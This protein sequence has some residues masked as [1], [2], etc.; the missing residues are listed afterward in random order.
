[1]SVRV[2]AF[3]FDGTLVASNEIKANAFFEVVRDRPGAVDA[4]KSVQAK[5]PNGT[6]FAI[7]AAVA[8]QM[9]GNGP[10][11]A[12]Q[13]ELWVD[14]YTRR[15]EEAIVAA[16]EIPGA[17]ACL[18]HLKAA[19]FK[20]Y[21]DSATPEAALASIV[22]RRG[23]EPFFTGLYGAPTGKVD[24][25]IRICHDASCGREEIA[26]V[27]DGPADVSAA[28]SFG[29][30]FFKVGAGGMTDLSELAHKLAI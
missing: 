20:L 21:L 10:V 16:P 2:V 29:C 15:C 18:R 30:V 28:A 24:N 22:R 27:G 12:A 11:A 19:G 5:M 9:L 7:F 3:D 17:A 13:S 8:K 4:L 23:L 6:R 14:A 26:L 25:L 1:M